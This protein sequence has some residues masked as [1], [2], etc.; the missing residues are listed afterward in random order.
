MQD[1]AGTVADITRQNIIDQDMEQVKMNKDDLI[2]INHDHDD[3]L[4]LKNINSSH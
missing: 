1:I 3:Q 4:Q 2:I